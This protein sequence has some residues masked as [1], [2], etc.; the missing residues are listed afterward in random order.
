MLDWLPENISLEGKEVDFLFYISYYLTTITFI[1][2]A[3][4]M[5]AFL[6]IYRQKP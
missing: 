1:L 4:K 5:A 2:V 6:I 3:V